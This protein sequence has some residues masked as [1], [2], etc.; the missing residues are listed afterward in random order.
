MG[1]LLVFLCLEKLCELFLR[2]S[3]TFSDDCF[4]ISLLFEDFVFVRYFLACLAS[5]FSLKSLAAAPALL[6][7]V[8]LRPMRLLSWLE[9][10]ICWEGCWGCY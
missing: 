9:A 3:K 10:C 2:G 4:L 1:E 6:A 5:I 8:F 7:S